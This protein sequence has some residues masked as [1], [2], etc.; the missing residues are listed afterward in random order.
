MIT[1]KECKKLCRKTLSEYRCKHTFNVCKQAEKLAKIHGCD[2]EKAKIAALLH[3]IAKEMPKEDMLRLFDENAIIAKDTAFRTPSVW[4]GVAAAIIAQTRLGVT[5]TEIL[6]AIACHT[7][8]RPNMTDLDKIIFLADM[9]SAERNYDGLKKLRR[10]CKKDLNVAVKTALI[11][12]M[13][14]L[15]E[16]NKDIDGYTEA[17]IESLADVEAEEM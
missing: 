16:K 14:W 6:D 3:D 8:G 4:H 17:A 9:T 10:L 2:V 11:M 7:A 13:G 12:N 15:K 5:D 1:I